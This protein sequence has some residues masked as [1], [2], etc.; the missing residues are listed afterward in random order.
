MTTLTPAQLAA[1]MQKESDVEKLR[2][3]RVVLIGG[4]M[5]PFAVESRA[6]AAGI[7]WVHT[8]GMTETASH[9]ALRSPGE[10]TFTPLPGVRVVAVPDAGPLSFTIDYGTDILEVYTRDC[11]QVNPDG[12]FSLLGRLDNVIISGGVKIH[13]E[14]LEQELKKAGWF[15]DRELVLAGVADELY[16]NRVVLFVEGPAKAIDIE[17]QLHAIQRAHPLLYLKEIRFWDILPRTSTGKVIRH[18]LA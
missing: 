10:T 16:G 7:A 2:R 11:G 8:Y 13:P 3:F 9:I 15:G 6:S 4:D 12:T 14:P 1:G 5:F 17:Q 18:L